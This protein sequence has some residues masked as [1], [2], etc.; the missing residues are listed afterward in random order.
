MYYEKLNYENME[1]SAAYTM[2]NVFS[3]A[4]GQ[5]G[6]WLGMSLVSVVEFIIV[7]NQVGRCIQLGALNDDFQVILGSIHPKAGEVMAF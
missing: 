3:D 7:I 6:L 4:G 2:T 1:E 5:I